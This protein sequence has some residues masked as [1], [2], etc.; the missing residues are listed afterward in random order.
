[1]RAQTPRRLLPRRRRGLAATRG[2]RLAAPRERAT[3]I[4][5]CK[6][7]GQVDDGMHVR[8]EVEVT[9]ADA[10]PPRR[11][12]DPPALL[13]EVVQPL[14]RR[15]LDVRLRLAVERDVRVLSQDGRDIGELAIDSVRAHWAG[16]KRRSRRSSGCSPTARRTAR[17]PRAPRQVAGRLRRRR[18]ADLRSLAAA[19]A[20]AK[21]PSWRA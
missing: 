2:R 19:P 4:L 3:R 14:T 12:E 10:P 8:R 15:A 21:S 5:T 7:R 6:L 18:Q 11:A 17:R 9:W 13:R 16:C 20:A 1:M